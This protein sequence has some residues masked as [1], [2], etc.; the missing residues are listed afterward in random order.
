MPFTFSHPAIVLPLKNTV[1]KKL[2]M[3]GLIIG[4]LTPDFEYFFRMKPY[5][6]FSHTLLGALWFDVPLGLALCFLFH[7]IIKKPFIQNLPFILQRKLNHVLECNW[8]LLFKQNW[9]FIV[10]SLII[11]AYSHILWDSFTHNNAFF[12]NLLNLD[13]TVG[14]T[15][16]PIY[17]LLQHGS[18][19]IGGIYIFRYIWNL[20][21]AIINPVKPKLNYWIGIVLITIIILGIRFLTGLSI[22]DYG[23][24][25]VSGITAMMVGTIIMSIRRL[26]ILTYYH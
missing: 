11:G 21:D 9:L 15:S 5:S 25:I 20:N 7:Q 3:T 17:K 1:G 8:A 13:Q 6:E 24:V 23:S 12:V 4:S 16:I 2:S 22:S 18:T 26:S 14:E 10:I 19:L